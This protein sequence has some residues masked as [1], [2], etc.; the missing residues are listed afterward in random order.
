MFSI[1]H[2]QSISFSGLRKRR[3]SALAARTLILINWRIAWRGTTP[4]SP[5]ATLASALPNA[6]DELEGGVNVIAPQHRP[7]DPACPVAA[8]P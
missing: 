8:F 2:V 7:V 1:L 3:N 4:E 6:L 5:K